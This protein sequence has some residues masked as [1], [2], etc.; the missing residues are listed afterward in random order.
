MPVQVP[1]TE[2]EL[3]ALLRVTAD[4]KAR[5]KG[6][7]RRVWLALYQKLLAATRTMT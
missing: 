5:P 1:L 7:R 2:A 6:V 4:D 3:I